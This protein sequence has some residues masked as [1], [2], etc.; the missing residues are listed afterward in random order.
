MER[1]IPVLALAETNFETEA[2]RCLEEKRNFII[3]GTSETDVCDTLAQVVPLNGYCP[4]TLN[5]WG[6]YALAE[7]L[8]PAD[9]NTLLQADRSKKSIC[10]V[11]QIKLPSTKPPRAALQTMTSSIPGNRLQLQRSLLKQTNSE[12]VGG[13]AKVN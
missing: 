4:D 2:A 11:E 10:I 1:P 8:N 13:L 5:R 3:V 12:P 6:I 7:V 9:L